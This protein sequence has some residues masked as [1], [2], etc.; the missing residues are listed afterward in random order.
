[1]RLN[2]GMCSMRHDF[3]RMF[4]RQA[5]AVCRNAWTDSSG[6]AA[7]ETGETSSTQVAPFV[8]RMRYSH[9]A[10][11]VKGLFDSG[12]HESQNRPDIHMHAYYPGLALLLSRPCEGPDIKHNLSVK[13]PPGP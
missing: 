5:H 2:R 4:A 13:D 10:L 9:M 1:M 12:R 6:F 11:H 8:Q 3:L 7:C